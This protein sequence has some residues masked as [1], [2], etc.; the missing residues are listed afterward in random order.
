MQS[1]LVMLGFKTPCTPTYLHIAETL[2]LEGYKHYMSPTPWSWIF[3]DAALIR[4][5]FYPMWFHK[6]FWK[7]FEITMTNKFKCDFKKYSVLMCPLCFPQEENTEQNSVT[8]LW[9]RISPKKCLTWES[10]ILLPKCT[11]ASILF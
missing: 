7:L 3:P 6:F 1:L 9:T 8:H 11:P 4:I 10:L 5:L 2:I